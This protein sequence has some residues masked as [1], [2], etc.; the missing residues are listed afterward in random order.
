MK[1]LTEVTRVGPTRDPP[2]KLAIKTPAP[3]QASGVL[4]TTPNA[5]VEPVYPKTM[6]A[7]A[8]INNAKEKMKCRSPTEIRAEHL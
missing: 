5:F 1:T 2:T 3:H 4:T 7:L 8:A 6:P